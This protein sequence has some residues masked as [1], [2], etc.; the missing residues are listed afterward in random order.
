NRPREEPEAI[1]QPKTLSIWL[2][3]SRENWNSGYPLETARSQISI[4]EE[5][6]VSEYWVK[7]MVDK[8]I[9]H[10]KIFLSI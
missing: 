8:V 3:S 7:C 5:Q 6:E 4:T 1:D 10:V 2:T 9:P